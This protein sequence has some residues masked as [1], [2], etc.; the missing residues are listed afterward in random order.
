MAIRACQR[1]LPV[2]STHLVQPC[3]H[4]TV[5]FQRP[6]HGFGTNRAILPLVS[7]HIRLGLF[8]HFLQNVPNGLLIDMPRATMYAD[9][10]PAIAT[11][12]RKSAAIARR[13]FW[14]R[15]K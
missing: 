3:F 8:C 5:Y 1:T 2:Q 13:T 9:D 14:Q 12:I 11:G 7:K 6:R 15:S 4:A 10:Y